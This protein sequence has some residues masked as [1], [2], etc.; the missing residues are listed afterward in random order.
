MPGMRDAWPSVSGRTCDSRW[1]TSRDRP[2]TRQTE[3]RPGS[4]A[5]PAAA[6]RSARDASCFEI[7]LV[8]DVVLEARD[9]ELARGRRRGRARRRRR[10]PA[11]AS[12]TS[13]CRSSCARRQRDRPAASAPAS[14]PARRR[15]ARIASRRASNA[16]HRASSTRPI[17]RPRGVSRRSALSMRSSSRCSAREVNIRYG[18]RQPRVTRSSTRMPMYA[19]SRRS[20]NGGSRR[21]APRG[22]DARHQPLRR[23]FFVAGRAVDLPGEE[24]PGDPMRLERRL[25]LGRLDEVVLDRISRPEHL[26]RLR[27]RAARARAAPGPRAAAT[28]RSR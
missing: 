18:S 9:V 21:D 22:V 1:T 15:S 5:A 20:V 8:L 26:A 25:Q 28:S 7:A 13:G 11:S 3:S 17:S 2:G 23:R 6:C 27:G 14:G 4:G 19:S 12:R 16:A 24:Q 10:R